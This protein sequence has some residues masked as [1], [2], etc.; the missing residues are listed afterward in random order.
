MADDSL[1]RYVGWLERTAAQHPVSPNPK[2]QAIGWGSEKARENDRIKLWPTALGINA[3]L[4]IRDI[5]EFRVWEVCEETFTPVRSTTS[6]TELDPVDLDAV[7]SS[8]LHAQ[9]MEIARKAANDDDGKAFYSF[10]LHGP[11]GSSKTAMAQALAGQMWRDPTD[12]HRQSNLVCITPADFTRH[13]E[14]RIESEARYIFDVLRH[15]RRVVIL[16]DEVDDLLRKRFPFRRLSYLEL[17]SPAMLN[18]LADLRNACPRQ[19]ICFI[20]STNF[21]DQIEPALLRRGRVDAALPVVYPDGGSRKLLIEKMLAEVDKSVSGG[22]GRFDRGAFIRRIEMATTFWPWIHI[23]DMLK[24]MK[25][26]ILRV[27]DLIT[28]EDVKNVIRSHTLFVK[29]PRYEARRLLNLNDS[30]ELRNE[31]LQYSFSG[32]NSATA[33]GKEF[34]RLF[35]KWLRKMGVKTEG[36]AWQALVEE[37]MKRWD[38]QG[39]PA[40]SPKGK[41]RRRKAIRR[42]GLRP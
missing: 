42:R 13:G 2:V 41:P 11:P 12:R 7:H 33:Y 4:E 34:A 22:M 1:D 24:E 35:V 30:P 25:S 15:V 23:N 27:R 3:L 38:V 26:L 19:E 6:L 39:R 40:N 21:I 18:R 31:V 28:T 5:L 8:R 36:S 14:D 29:V 10:V 20:F 9:M 32:W 37:G 17:L 16:F